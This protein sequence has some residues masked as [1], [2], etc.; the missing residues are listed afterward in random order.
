MRINHEIHVVAGAILAEGGLWLSWQAQHFL[1][2][3]EP[4]REMLYSSIQNGSQ[5]RTSKVSK[6]ADARSRFHGRIMFGMSQDYPP[7]I[8]FILADV[9][10]GRR[11]T[12]WVWRVTLTLLALRIVN[13]V[14]YAMRINHEIHFAWQAQYLLNLKGDF[15]CSAQCKC[16]FICETDQSWDLFRVA[17]AVFA[18]GGG[19]TLVAPRMVNDAS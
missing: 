16:R 18:E 9:M 6:A 5:D 15:A 2:F 3:W 17:G 19:F 8:V 13:D 12:C 4:G 1:T 7:R 10:Q 14:A 11:S